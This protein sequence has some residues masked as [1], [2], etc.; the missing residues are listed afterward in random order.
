M[1]ELDSSNDTER[2][3]KIEI[4]SNGVISKGM[5]KGLKLVSDFFLLIEGCPY[6]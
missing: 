4:L 3:N 2:S 5:N 6:L 1:S